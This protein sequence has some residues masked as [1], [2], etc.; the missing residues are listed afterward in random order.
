[1]LLAEKPNAVNHLLSALTRRRQSF[2]EAGVLA[3][4][5]L[6]AFR[7]H[8]ALDASRL[9]GLEAR[10]GLERASTKGCQLVA[11]MLDELLELCERRSFRSCAV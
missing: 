2:R 1:M 4:Q 10:L 11:E 9:Q 3:L 8:D 7:R 6:D 5:E